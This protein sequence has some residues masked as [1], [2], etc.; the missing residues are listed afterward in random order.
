MA[1]QQ[2]LDYIREQ[3]NA[4]TAPE[5][6]KNALAKTGWPSKYIDEGF[7]ELGHAPVTSPLQINPQT[8]GQPIIQETEPLRNSQSYTPL[9][10]NDQTSE[11]STYAEPNHKNRSGLGLALFVFGLI[12]ILG[13]AVAYGYI[14]KIGPFASVVPYTEDNLFSGLLTSSNLINSATY[15]FKSA[16]TI[17]PRD[18]NAMSWKG[19][20]KPNP[21]LD[22]KYKR[23]YKR[24]E[25]I[26]DILG[27][28]TGKKIPYPATIQEAISYSSSSYYRIEINDPTTNKP[29]EYKATENG[30][31]FSITVTFETDNAISAIKKAY[32]YSSTSTPISNKQVTFTKNS[33]NYFYLPSTLPKPLILQLEES[34]NYLPPGTS[35]DFSISA[36]ADRNEQ[37]TDWK[38]N[39]TANGDFGDLTYKVNL[40]TLRKNK[41]YYFKINNF[42]DIFLAFIPSIAALKGS[43]IKIAGNSTSTAP[44]SLDPLSML[45]KEIPEAEESYKKNKQEFVDALKKTA[46]IADSENLISFKN[47]PKSEQ[48]D[49]RNLYRYDLKINKEAILPFYKKILS[50]NKKINDSWPILDDGYV[51][52]L[53]SSEFSEIFDFYDKNTS[54][55]L[56]VDQNGF[57]AILSYDIRVTPP[58]SAIQ[59]KEKQIN[60]VLKL[61]LTDI[62]ES[63]DIEEPKDAKSLEDLAS[64]N[65]TTSTSIKNNN[66]SIIMC[67]DEV[68]F[69]PEFKKCA[70][71]SSFT[72]KINTDGVSLLTI[73]GAESGKCNIETKIIKSPLKNFENKTMVCLLN[74]SKNFTDAA[75]ELDSQL[76]S[77]LGQSPCKGE[78]FEIMK[79][80]K[81]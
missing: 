79:A 13:S 73:I 61:T 36:T 9:S 54:L 66:N 22:A 72:K 78:L 75:I 29:F 1:N 3:T 44:L 4:G 71:G 74:N 17:N 41:N 76:N 65:N 50:E 24:S 48:V 35:G 15:E 2:L 23:D 53:E 26:A 45:A 6:I 60:I 8:I 33:A 47:S 21:D 57:P 16:L 46:E 67:N 62:N 55:T 14:M 12:I 81:N 25:A 56:W 18:A 58:D 34:F 59:L 10:T 63:I 38:F 37:N 64:L 70:T 51:A 27:E 52:Y 80:L 68:C 42:P 31:N 77:N 19:T 5:E 43:W 69:N 40:D 30:N 20:D 28:L 39:V 11:N 49:R 7:S 32:K